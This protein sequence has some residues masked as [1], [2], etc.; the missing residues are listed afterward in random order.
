MMSDAVDLVERERVA[1]ENDHGVWVR[2]GGLGIAGIIL[3]A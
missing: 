3:A 1:V 2:A